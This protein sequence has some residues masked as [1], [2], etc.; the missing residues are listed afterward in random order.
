M[1]CLF[2]HETTVCYLVLFENVLSNKRNNEKPSPYNEVLIRINE[3]P[4]R[5]IFPL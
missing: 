1:K 2:I 4:S 5:K 3:K